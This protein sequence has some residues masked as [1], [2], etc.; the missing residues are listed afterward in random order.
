[1]Q[2]NSCAHDT[3]VHKSTLHFWSHTLLKEEKKK[4]SLYLAVHVATL[5][6]S[7]RVSVPVL[8]CVKL[9]VLGT[10]LHLQGSCTHHAIQI[11]SMSHT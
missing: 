11:V 4:K 8:L 2:V 10:R 9:A 6:V 5:L 3:L 1:M 7:L